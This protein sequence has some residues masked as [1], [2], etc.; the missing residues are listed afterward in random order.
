MLILTLKNKFW[1]LN[2]VKKNQCVNPV[3][4]TQCCIKVTVV[5]IIQRLVNK[6]YVGEEKL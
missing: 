5:I 3:L 1:E 4:G 2:E 6:E